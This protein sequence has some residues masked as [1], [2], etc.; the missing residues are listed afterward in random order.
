MSDNRT[1]AIRRL[2]NAAV[3]YLDK[4]AASRGIGPDDE[5]WIVIGAA[6]RAVV[7]VV[8]HEAREEG[9]A[10]V[11]EVRRWV[12]ILAGITLVCTAMLLATLF[13]RL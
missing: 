5:L 8:L 7:P 12:W 4:W 11:R 1:A 3:N 13:N 10:I 6:L 2:P 9:R